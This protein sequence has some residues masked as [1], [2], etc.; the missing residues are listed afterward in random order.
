MNPGHAAGVVIG[1]EVRHVAPAIG[2]R[3]CLSP[4]LPV[5]VPRDNKDLY[6]LQSY[7]TSEERKYPGFLAVID[8]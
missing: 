2:L 7:R 5:G 3:S 6:A 4:A 1:E 8:K